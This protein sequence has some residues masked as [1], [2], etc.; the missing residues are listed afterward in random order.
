MSL[1]RVRWDKLPFNFDS[2]R[3]N[4]P[5]FSFLC[6]SVISLAEESSD[7]HTLMS[8]VLWFHLWHGPRFI[9]R[10]QRFPPR[11]DWPRG[12]KQVSDRTGVE[13]LTLPLPRR[14]RLANVREAW[15]LCKTIQGRSAS[16]LITA[17]ENRAR[18]RIPEVWKV[19][20]RP[21]TRL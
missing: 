12:A 7:T 16:N 20:W 14:N 18:S 17:A 1:V 13:S 15:T 21:G 5:P 19:C 8:V 4:T 6:V 3:S 2:F 11:P 9:S 10:Q